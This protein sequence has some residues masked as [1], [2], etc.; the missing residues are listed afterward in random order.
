MTKPLFEL[1]KKK[2]KT[3]TLQYTVQCN[4]HG[5]LNWNINKISSIMEQKNKKKYM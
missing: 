3:V 5:E 4:V 2:K 1:I